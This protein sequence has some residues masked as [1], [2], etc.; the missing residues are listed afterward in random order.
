MTDAPT[1][2][3][4]ASQHNQL[5]DYLS[6]KDIFNEL[7]ATELIRR[8]CLDHAS[9]IYMY[10]YTVCVTNLQYWREALQSDTD[11]NNSLTS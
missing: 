7:K 1:A 6:R 2:M 8:Y 3:M 10:E 9:I 4:I 5:R 11:C